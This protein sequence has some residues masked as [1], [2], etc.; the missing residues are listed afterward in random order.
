MKKNCWDFK[1]CGRQPGGNKTSEL[2]VCPACNEKK[3]DGVHAGRN[4][5]RSCWVV[6]G[7]FCG[8]EKQGSFASKL[9]SCMACDFYRSVKDVE[10]KGFEMSGALLKKMK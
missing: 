9:S 5:G 6:A 2:G 10:G 1:Q 3:L 4:A 8:G 7:T